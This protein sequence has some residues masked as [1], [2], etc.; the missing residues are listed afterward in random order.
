MHLPFCS[1]Q[2]NFPSYFVLVIMKKLS[3]GGADR[4]RVSYPI[5][6]SYLGFSLIGSTDEHLNIATF[7]LSINKNWP[8]KALNLTS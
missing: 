6:L 8:N 7:G 1:F 5:F 3:W 4:P 2:L